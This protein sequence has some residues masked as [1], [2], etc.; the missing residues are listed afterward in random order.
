[1]VF[2]NKR[3]FGRSDHFSATSATA[4]QLQVNAITDR[5]GHAG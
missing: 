1:M 5:Y 2:P 3:V 4:V